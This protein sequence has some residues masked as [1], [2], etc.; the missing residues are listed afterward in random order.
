MSRDIRTEFCG[1]DV[2]VRP[3]RDGTYEVGVQEIKLDG[4]KYS[5]SWYNLGVRRR[6][7]ALKRAPG[8]VADVLLEMGVQHVEWS[9]QLMQ[10]ASDLAEL[11]TRV[12]AYELPAKADG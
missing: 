5:W 3:S 7:A 12:R 11:A 6:D 9:K 2:I 10:R 4:T 1:V 8:V